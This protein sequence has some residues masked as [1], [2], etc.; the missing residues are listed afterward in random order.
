MRF[1]FNFD[2]GTFSVHP[3]CKRQAF[4]SQ[5]TVCLHM[6]KIPAPTVA[7]AESQYS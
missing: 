1:S 2:G 6:Q 3:G 5:G 7:L 4:L